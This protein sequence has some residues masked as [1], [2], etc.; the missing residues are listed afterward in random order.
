MLR[1]ITY[2]RGA[3]KPIVVDLLTA[4]GAA[5]NITGHGGV[6]LGISSELGADD[7]ILK[8]DAD[9]SIDV[10]LTPAAVSWTPTVAESLELPLGTL[11][12]QVWVMLGGNWSES[13]LIEFVVSEGTGKPTA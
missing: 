13:Q 11:W 3:T 8:T 10:T 6:R 4:A 5:E 2:T 7:V 1:R 9:D 12:L